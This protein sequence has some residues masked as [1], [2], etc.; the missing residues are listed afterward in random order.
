MGPI[1]FNKRRIFILVAGVIAFYIVFH[2]LTLSGDSIRDVSARLPLPD[3]LRPSKPEQPLVADPDDIWDLDPPPP[4]PAP[5]SPTDPSE[6]PPSESQ[7]VAHF[8]LH[9]IN[10]LMQEA[11]DTWRAYETS[12]SKSFRQTVEKYRSKYGRHPPPGFKEWY[13][14]A[15]K[16][17]VFNIDDF[18]QIMDDLRPFWAINASEIR[19]R[20]AHMWEDEAFGAAVIH[21]RD[22]KI[23]RTDFPSWRSDTMVEVISKFIEF[24]PDMDIAMNRLDQPRVVVPWEDMQEMLSKE[25]ETRAMPPEVMDNFTTNQPDLLDM[26]IEDKANDNSTR[27]DDGW[28]F[29]PGRQYMDIASKAC[30]PESPARS[31]M[32]IA[33][34]DAMYKEP[35]AGI[36]SNFNLSSDLCTVGPAIQNLHGLLYTASS[37]I[38]SHKLVP[39]FGECKVNVNNDILF[40]ANMYYLHDERYDYNPEGDVDWRD[41]E[42]SIIW[43]GVTSGGV[44]TEDNWPTMHRQRLV[45]LLNGTH[46]SSTGTKVRVL[47]AKRDGSH[48]ENTTYE[49]YNHF[50]AA[51]FADQHSDVGFVEA[52]GCV[53][54]CSFYDQ[55]F[56]WKP[57]TSLTAQFKS[58]YL[59]DVDGHSFSGRWHAFLQSKSLGLKATIFREWHDSRLLAWRHFVPVDN[60][61]DD[62]YSLLSYFMGYG[63]PNMEHAL[64]AG[65][66][67]PEVYIAAH[68]REAQKL[69]RQGRE[70]ANKVLRR[71][72]IEVY[73]FRLLLEYGRLIDDNRDHIGYS[74]DGSELDKFDAG[75]ESSGRWGIGGWKD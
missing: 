25:Y 36:V 21:I 30:P 64:E 46:L 39:I 41:K 50:H 8:D 71:E 56:S 62:I 32:S 23:A 17:N 11:D 7:N 43:R 35:E 34:A 37:I 59:I 6:S 33:Q 24:L 2:G 57:Q 74:G 9:P 40:P 65:D 16:R 38:A 1:E 14:F 4:A 48:L 72:D 18:E 68:P 10:R 70:W 61:Y 66:P 12:I 22:H 44:Q 58:K 67:N 29:A 42:D 45:Q 52:W 75:D 3:S 15:R 73:T 26:S 27:L 69:A 51:Q 31:N 54:D 5:D 55:I 60:R 28:F 19:T 13:K 49:P 20:A 47:T 53:P 63:Q